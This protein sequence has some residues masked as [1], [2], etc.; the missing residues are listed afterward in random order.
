MWTKSVNQ[1]KNG[2]VRAAV[3]IGGTYQSAA[4]HLPEISGVPFD[5][6]LVSDVKEEVK[7]AG[8]DLS[9]PGFFSISP[10]D[11]DQIGVLISSIGRQKDR[12]SQ[13]IYE[14]LD[15]QESDATEGLA[16]VPAIGREA[17]LRQCDVARATIREFWNYLRTVAGGAI[18][19]CE[20]YMFVSLAGGTGCG[21]WLLMD[22]LLREQFPEHAHNATLSL[23]YVFTDGGSY[24]GCGP[25]VENNGAAGAARVL[26]KVYNDR[27]KGDNEN[28][29]YH[30]MTLPLVG[31]DKMARD[32]YVRQSVAMLMSPD[33]RGMNARIGA[34]QSTTTRQKT[35]KMFIH[36]FTHFGEITEVDLIASVARRFKPDVESLLATDVAG[37]GTPMSELFATTTLVRTPTRTVKSI[38]ADRLAGRGHVKG[39]V[40][41]MEGDWEATGTA[42]LKL[43]T[44]SDTLAITIIKRD[45]NTSGEFRRY[46][47]DDLQLAQLVDTAINKSEGDLRKAKARY[48]KAQKLMRSHWDFI[49]GTFFDKLMKFQSWPLW[50]ERKSKRVDQL[51]IA[52]EKCR[53]AK[54]EVALCE[55]ALNAIQDF[56][57][58]LAARTAGVHSDI[59]KAISRLNEVT[60]R[61]TAIDG[62]D[63][64]PLDTRLTDILW[65]TSLPDTEDLEA[66]LASCVSALSA[67][68]IARLIFGYVDKSPATPTILASIIRKATPIHIGT[69]W[70]QMSRNGQS[71]RVYVFVPMSSDDIEELQKAYHRLDRRVQIAKVSCGASAFVGG[72]VVYTVNA[73]QEVVT[74]HY[75]T[76]LQT[77]MKDPSSLALSCAPGE[78]MRPD[79]WYMMDFQASH[80]SNQK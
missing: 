50:I 37:E 15:G 59:R 12:V 43:Q 2:Q 29:F 64:M 55:A 67:D 51:E 47:V 3:I 45:L 77:M 66:I 13:L 56:R 76:L 71:G 53:D 33:Y 58:Q 38:I 40:G 17:L 79:P 46:L 52:A 16:Q 48:V 9:Q 30:L 10:K 28:T 14:A 35:G 75:D 22:S 34:N 41:E 39:L 62:V 19:K 54:E 24:L 36:R 21:Q 42:Y 11:T 60:L 49:F 61:G 18:T 78:P 23:R 1:P 72:A 69:E 4:R 57:K 68:T 5:A 6:I 20:I 70:G 74:P 26:A 44:G 7:Q 27:D 63:V 8:I 73:D 65:A 32:L 31:T 25:R 80:H